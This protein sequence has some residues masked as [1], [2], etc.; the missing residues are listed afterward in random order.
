MLR[1]AVAVLLVV[2]AGTA[3]RADLIPGG[4]FEGG[5]TPS[6]FTTF[7]NSAVVTS[8]GTTPAVVP[9][10][11]GGS[12]FVEASS[13]GV[14]SSVPAG[15]GPAAFFTGDPA[16]TGFSVVEYSGFS[17]TLTLGAGDILSF[18]LNVHTGEVSGGV[19]D[20][21][22]IYV[23]SG[24]GATARL[25][26]TIG[27][28]PGAPFIP[29]P[30]AAFS[31]GP[32]V[33]P[34][35]GSFFDGQTGWFSGAIPLSAGSHTVYFLVADTSDAVVETGFGVDN[36]RLAGTVIPEPG[37]MALFATG[38][39]AFAGVAIRRRRRAATAPG[40]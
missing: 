19:P 5:G 12:F 26:F 15:S 37:T 40:A 33:D 20:I 24:G 31:G 17:F 7:G 4:D 16:G 29:L 2:G 35:F 34:L 13:G 22:A 21:V 27:G 6:G 18:L 38:L 39:A 9:A 32:I 14:V 28:S 10:V 30:G 11:G 1:W 8:V 25:G 3:A 23:D 36:L